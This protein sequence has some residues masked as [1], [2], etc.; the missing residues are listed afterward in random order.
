MEVT[1][2]G[3]TTVVKLVQASNACVPMITTLVG[4]VMDAKLFSC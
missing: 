3:I 4:I 2:F 1:L